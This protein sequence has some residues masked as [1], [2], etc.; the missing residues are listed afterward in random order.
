MRFHPN[1]DNVDFQ[2]TGPTVRAHDLRKG[3]PYKEELFNAVYHSHVLEH[4]PRN[5]G[6]RFLRECYRVLRR[7][8]V[9]RVAVPDLEGIVRV[10]LEKLEK[11]SHGEP[12]SADDYD[13]MLLEMYDQAIR[14]EPCG[15]FAEY[16][17]RDPIPNWD[18]VTK[19]W[20]T[21]AETAVQGIRKA[22]T[23]RDSSRTR[24]AWSYV[25]RNPATFVYNRLVRLL[26]SKDDRNALQIGRFRRAG[27]VHM[28]MYDS[29]SLARL[30]RD[31]GF[32]QPQRVGATESKIPGWAKFYLDA[33]PDGQVYKADSMYMEAFKP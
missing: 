5:E 27:E 12:G 16:V 2:Q 25:L 32:V 11:V 4:F 29:Y 10:Y 8:G 28:W 15:G 18:F 13:W 6:K 9:V 31:V 14:E 22:S 24:I 17:R 7:G 21:F 23:G 20:G 3:I 26:L 1:W 33:D 19:R 30:L